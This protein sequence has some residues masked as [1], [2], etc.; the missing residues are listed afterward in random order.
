MFKLSCMTMVA[1]LTLAAP[2][3]R[4]ET[5]INIVAAENFYGDLAKQIGGQRV[6][7]T[8]VLSNPDADPHLFET[9]AS[10][11]R[12]MAAAQVVVY[13]GADY[14][15]WMV[16][17]L[18][19][20]GRKPDTIVA[21]D[22]LGR[23][24]GDNP[25][26]WYDP[27][28]FPAV[29]KALARDLEKLDPAHAADYEARLAAFDASFST[30]ITDVAQIKREHGGTEVTA[31]EPVFGYMASALG[32]K[33]LNYPFQIAIMNNAEPSP[34][35]VIAFEKS[36]SD[37][38]AK[39]LFYNSQVTDKT[40][41]RLLAIAKAHKVVVIGVTETEPNGMTIQSWFSGQLAEIKKDLTG[42]TM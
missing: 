31:T 32:F 20:A 40:T 17:L 41:E 8:S 18:S 26:L 14:D 22:L 36:L 3:A 38:Q 11:A 30:A 4:A 37:G 24:P 16:K 39:V 19:A 12:D 9:S 13:N 29:A 6:A 21:A 2:L 28:T 1:A 35:E 42:K 23:K 15:P 5:P 25:H 34:S 10:T 7:V 33:M 27:A